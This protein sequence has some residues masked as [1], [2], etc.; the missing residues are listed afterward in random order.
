MAVIG[1][2]REE[3]KV[4]HVV[5]N[6]LIS[7]FKGKIYGVNPNA[8]YVLG[9][10]SHSSIKD[11]KDPVELA[12][13]CIPAGFVLEAVK[14]CAKKGV[15][16]VLIISSGFS[17]IGNIDLEN[18]L[19]D[20]LNKN[21]M[22]AVGVNCLGVLDTFSSLDTIFIPKNRMKRPRKG[23]ISFVTQSGA[24]GL[25]LLD[26]L[27]TENYGFSKFVSY[28]NGTN[29]DEADYLEF[30]KDD[31]NTKVICVYIEAVKDG[32]KFMKIA[33]E[34]AKKKPVIIIKG[35]K[36]E[37]GAQA[38]LSHTGSL[39]GSQEIYSS[40]FKQ[41][42]LIEVNTLRE[43]FN[44]AKLFEKLEL[45]NLKPKGKKIQ[46]I[47]NGGGY[48]IL[49]ADSV[50]EN[51]LEL[52]EISI[53]L[54]KELKKKLAPIV[55][56]KNPLDLTGIAKDSD[57]KFVLENCIKEKDIDI[58][59]TIVLPQT[60]L[61]SENIV[62]LFSEIN[63]QKKKPLVVISTGGDFTKFIKNRMEDQ[64]I[65]VFEFPGDAVKAIKRMVDYYNK[66]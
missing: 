38:A 43:M 49:T 30:L 39:A 22:Q 26:L 42:K 18:Q 9:F 44:L 15:K 6:N 20:L 55:T 17:E 51:N 3:N 5:F 57:Y 31:E 1:V 60:P 16:N 52:P 46:I 56:V 47:T 4:G 7:S 12:I 21:N 34:V 66:N 50:S 53:N 41:C 27:A 29:V 59:L 64:N 45:M 54:K 36:T 8:D 58:L 24:L 19:K 63:N 10:K 62:N 65:P 37:K 14:D 13:I 25:A 40:V 28:G 11:I 2:S 32:K 33:S 23:Y 48:G 61:I 35:G